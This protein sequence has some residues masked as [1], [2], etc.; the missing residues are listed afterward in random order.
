MDSSSSSSSNP[1]L[2]Q[3]P[4][5]LL[6]PPEPAPP[7]PLPEA[8]VAGGVRGLLRSGEA[9]IR[10]VFRGNSGHPRPHLQHQ[11]HH[12]H[13]HQP[14]Q[15]HHRPGDI[16]KRLQRETFS[17]VMK[18]KEK[19]DQIEHILSLYKS[20][21]GFEFLDLPIQ[22]KIALDAV[23]ALFLVD[24]NEFEQAKA[25]LNKAGKRTGLSSRFVF[26]SKTRGKDT[27]A[28][29]LSTRLGGAGAHLGEETGRPVELTSLQYNARI[30]KWLSMIL[31]PFGA[32]CNNFLH[33]SSMI[34]NLRSQACFDGPPS[35]L[36]HHNCAAGLRIEGSKFTASFAE[37]I[38]GSGGLDSGGGG[39]NR[40]TTF[41]QVSC[42]PNNDVKLSLSG[43][44]QVRSLSSR[45]NNLGI[46][47]IPLGSLKAGAAAA[48]EHTEL[49][50]MVDASQS[51]ALMV[52]CELYETLKT[53][54]WFQLERPDH[55]PVHWGFSLSDIPENELGW[56]VRVGGTAEGKKTHHLQHLD[57]EGYLNFNLGKGARL[58][59]GLVYAKMGE[60][61]TPALFLRSSWFM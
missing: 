33:S 46:L 24:G 19:H 22:V 39:T 18:F 49:S 1:A 45:F 40:M 17:D 28:A 43:L 13:H 10:A 6:P 11:Q 35:F 20:G 21:K 5:L 25:T 47:A 44:W 26:E 56:G 53:E 41:G 23:G 16:M 34:Q 55:G 7:L 12:L 51:I 4:P 9:L 48:E 59:P 61:M 52:D 27:V 37:L 57:L 29:E 14:Q 30:N 31:V 38:F 32:Q 54:G 60:K 3:P 15:Q 50:V 42:K 58:Q 2:P 8:T 36:E